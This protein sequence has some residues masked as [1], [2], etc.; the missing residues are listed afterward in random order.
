MKKI[1]YSLFTFLLLLTACGEKDTFTLKGSIQGLPS[2]TILVY[3]QNPSFRLDTIIA[4]KGT[5]AYTFAP[6]TFTIFSLLLTENEVLP[7]FADKGQEVIVKGDIANLQLKGEGNNKEM[8]SLLQQLDTLKNDRSKFRQ[9]VDSLIE[10]RPFS[11]TNIYL[12]NKYYVQD[13][14]PNYE[15]IEELVKGLSGAVKDTPYML[16]LQGKLENMKKATERRIVSSLNGRDEKGKLVGWNDVK[17]K[18]VL[19]NFWAS[20]DDKSRIVQDSLV[21]IQKA[22]KKEKFVIISLSLDMDKQEWLKAIADRDT[23]Q[24]KQLCDFKGWNNEIVKQQGITRLPANVLINP[25]RRVVGN[26][27]YGEELVD[28]VKS[29]IKQDEEKEKAAKERRKRN[30]R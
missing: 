25:N 21:S 13:T 27:L 29:L 24:W 22:L 26:D 6:D 28:K 16:D 10:H 7:V 5:F 12:I 3:Y 14:L 11:F 15:K 1:V 20:W 30:R 23:T 19:L 17:N 2:D 4:D 18:Y 8:S 9:T